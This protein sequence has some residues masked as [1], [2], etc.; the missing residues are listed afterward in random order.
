MNN[1]SHFREEY[2][3]QHQII[4]SSK[5]ENSHEL[6]NIVTVDADVSLNES[7]SVIKSNQMSIPGSEFQKLVWRQI[8]TYYDKEAG[9]QK[10]RELWRLKKFQWE[11]VIN[12]CYRQNN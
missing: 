9:K 6:S 5:Q 8:V 4:N 10:H 11:S 3:S 1:R 2:E 12:V 7:V